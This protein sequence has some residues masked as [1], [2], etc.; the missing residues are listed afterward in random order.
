MANFGAVF[1][2]HNP[3]TPIIVS[4]FGDPITRFGAGG[5]PFKEMAYWADGYGPQWYYGVWSV[6]ADHGVKAAINWADSQCGAA[7]GE[8]FPMVPELSIYSIYTDSGI[9]PHHDITTGE[10]YSKDWK[11]PVFWWEY[12]NMNASIAAACLA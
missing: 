11:A 12:S 3:K 8:R 2:K 6:Y 4:G 7:F 10:N 5:W 9:L 1:R